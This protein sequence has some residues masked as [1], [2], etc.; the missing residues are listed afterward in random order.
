[1]GYSGL[2][3]NALHRD[4]EWNCRIISGFSGKLNK[5]EEDWPARYELVPL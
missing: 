2:R 3:L 1:L 5:K 4:I